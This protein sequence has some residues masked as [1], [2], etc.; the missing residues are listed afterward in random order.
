MAQ[1]R[2]ESGLRALDSAW[3]SRESKRGGMQLC[4]SRLAEPNMFNGATAF[5]ADIG[6][7]N[8]AIVATMQTARIHPESRVAVSS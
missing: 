3:H 4:R 7:W 2:R 6:A 8:T 1:M 5:N